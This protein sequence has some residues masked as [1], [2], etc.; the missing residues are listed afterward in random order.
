MIDTAGREEEERYSLALGRIKQI[1]QEH[2][3]PEGFRDFFEKEAAFLLQ[4]D[5]LAGRLHAGELRD[6]SLKELEQINRDIYS[7]TP[8]GILRDV[9]GQSGVRCGRAGRRVRKIFQLSVRGT[10]GRDCLCL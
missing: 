2:S 8:S 4:M 6:A 10:A 9:L 7:E 1:R 3:V 5:A